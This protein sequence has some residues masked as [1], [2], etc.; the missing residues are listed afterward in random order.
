MLN[1]RFNCF[2]V[3]RK[4]LAAQ[5]SLGPHHIPGDHGLIKLESTLILQGSV[6]LSFFEEIVNTPFGFHPSS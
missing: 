5:L 1:S 6:F 3:W 4:N 2:S